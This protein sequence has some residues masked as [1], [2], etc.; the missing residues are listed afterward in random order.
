M[1]GQVAA[2]LNTLVVGY[3][4]NE[5]NGVI[6]LELYIDA[7]L[8]GIRMDRYDANQA[9][10]NKAN[11]KTSLNMCFQRFVHVFSTGRKTPNDALS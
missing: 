2:Y 3:P 11:R 8:Q 5:G 7:E 9:R 6:W 4:A 10:G 1:Y